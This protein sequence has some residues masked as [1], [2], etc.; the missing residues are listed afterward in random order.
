MREQLSHKFIKGSGI[1][2]GGLNAPLAGFDAQVTYV[3][4]APIEEIKASHPDVKIIADTY[5]IDSAE[6]L[7]NF[8]NE[9]QD[10]VIA[11]HVLEHCENPIKAIEN[12]VRVLK[13]GGVIFAA[14][15]VCTHTFDKRRA[16]TSFEHLLVDYFSSPDVSLVDHYYDWFENSELEGLKGH[17]LH[18]RVQAALATRSNI[19][20]HVWDLPSIKDLG[21]MFARFFSLSYELHEN[22]AEAILIFKKK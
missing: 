11:N 15:P 22:G 14:I 5:V 13:P 16:V 8:A 17:E 19:H 2:I 4:R 18:Q 21:V 9:S 7:K 12:W 6:E 20:F 3:D 1:E 10:F